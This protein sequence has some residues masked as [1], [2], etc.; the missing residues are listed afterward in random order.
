[1]MKIRF[2]L[3]DGGRGK[4]RGGAHLLFEIWRETSTKRKLNDNVIRFKRVV[5]LYTLDM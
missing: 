4:R 3:F 5:T 1:M 2:C